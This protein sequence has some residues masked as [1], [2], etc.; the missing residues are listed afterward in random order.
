MVVEQVLETRE[1]RWICEMPVNGRQS[2]LH[3]SWSTRDWA[4]GL[5]EAKVKKKAKW[6]TR[7]RPATTRW[8]IGGNLMKDSEEDTIC[9]QMPLKML[10]KM[11]IITL[12]LLSIS[13]PASNRTCSSCTSLV[14]QD[15][16]I[17]EKLY[18]IATIIIIHHSIS[19]PRTY[20]SQ[21]VKGRRRDGMKSA[22]RRH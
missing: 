18:I 2:E 12:L 20:L 13:L 21:V 3:N 8:C 5:W 19:S 17:I 16:R 15:C 7:P 14:S 10:L 22:I 1:W 4:D 9:S 6:L 11:I